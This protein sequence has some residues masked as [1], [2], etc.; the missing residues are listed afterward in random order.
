LRQD[1]GDI[2]HGYEDSQPATAMPENPND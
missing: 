1:T 2:G